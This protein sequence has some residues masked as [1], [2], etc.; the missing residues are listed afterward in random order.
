MG[1]R[2]KG[3]DKFGYFFFF[4]V[5]QGLGFRV[6]GLDYSILWCILHW[7]PHTRGNLQTAPRTLAGTG[8][9]RTAPSLTSSA[10]MAACSEDK[11]DRLKAR[12]V[13]R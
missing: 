11:P 13:E 7:V 10:K 2:V 4:G 12:R 9:C 8:F 1:F 6:Q 3:L 5:P